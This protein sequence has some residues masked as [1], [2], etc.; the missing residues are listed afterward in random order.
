MGA[1]H[2]CTA[3]APL[4][5]HCNSSAHLCTRLAQFQQRHHEPRITT[6]T[7]RVQ[8]ADAFQ[9]EAT[10]VT[11]DAQG[12][13]TVDINISAATSITQ[14]GLPVYD[15]TNPVNNTKAA[16]DSMRKLIT[17]MNK[18]VD[19]LYF[20]NKFERNSPRKDLYYTA[21]PHWTT[22]SGG[23][24]PVIMATPLEICEWVIAA[25][26]CVPMIKDIK[27]FIIED[28]GT[29][30]AVTIDDVRSRA[31]PKKPVPRLF[32]R[33]EGTG[34]NNAG[35]STTSSPSDEVI[36]LRAQLAAQA[37]SLAALQ[38]LLDKGEPA[39]PAKTAANKRSR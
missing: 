37:E 16:R 1:H 18:D 39:T 24:Q 38:A 6:L 11:S 19:P 4:L 27:I 26:A 33:I 5:H 35:S 20:R 2:N 12:V 36:Q 31:I 17:G 21:A 32:H 7:V 15:R 23:S 34:P 13:W 3:A 28:N 22:L 29:K 10:S 8:D 9:G 25:A 30:T 14:I